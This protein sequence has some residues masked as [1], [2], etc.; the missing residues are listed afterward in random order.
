VKQWTIGDIPNQQ[1]KV[2]IVTGANSG[3]GLETTRALAAKG[4]RVIMA[5]RDLERGQKAQAEILTSVPN[6]S[7]QAVQLD[8]ASLASIR[9]FAASF[10]AEH[11]RL[12]LLFNNAGVMAIPRRETQD[13]FE[14]QFGTNHLGH[15]ALTGLLLPTLLTTLD[16]RVITT[17]SLARQNGRIRFDDL[18]RQ[19]SYGR[20]EAYGQS[21]KANLLF[22]FEFQKRL[23][24]ARAGTIS[25]AA[26]P[27]AA[28]TNLQGTS[29]TLSGA[30]AERFLYATLWPLLSQ[31][32]L[33]GALPQLYAGTDPH[34]YGGELVGP[35]GFGGMRGY[36]AVDRKARKEYD[37]SVAAR[38]WEI[39]TELTGVDYAALTDSS[40]S[41]VSERPM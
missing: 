38:L 19:R 34:I 36:P 4:A 2:V 30:R 1:G 18:Q 40:A 8:L 35:G 21:K 20:W 26:H 13:G 15:F 24:A 33:M 32:A 11:G 27:G 23:T 12:D 37:R 7:V 28:N 6:A 10:Q 39:S 14:M 41:V 29:V 16:S 22:A 25:V 9:Q 31:S 5:C 17:T 3:L